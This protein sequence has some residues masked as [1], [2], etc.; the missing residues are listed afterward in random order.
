MNILVAIDSSAATHAALAATLARRWPEGTDFRV[1]TVIPGNLRDKFS[2]GRISPDIFRAHRLIDRATS[3]IEACNEDSI[4]TGEIDAGNPTQ[5]I[6]RGAD[7]WPADLVIVGSH[8]RGPLETLFM[9]S[10]SK[11]VMHKANCSVLVARNLVETPTGCSPMNRVMLAIDD[12]PYSKAAVDSVLRSMWPENTRFYI[13]SVSSPMY[14]G[15]AYEPS[16]MAVS[17]ALEY[18]EERHREVEEMVLGV[19]R[20]FEGTFGS[21]NVECG[22][23]EGHPEDVILKTARDWGAHLI[24]V[25]SHGRPDVAKRFLGSVSQT[26]AM[27]ADCSVQIVRS[28]VAQIKR[29]KDRSREVTKMPTASGF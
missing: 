23:I 12:S 6:T 10:V 13:L 11:S 8:E 9:G 2:G 17:W 20:Q 29:I 16:A 5:S 28:S 24:V 18:Q 7:V 22:V 4:V 21:G 19:S 15:F 1:L 25:G 14:S 3:E 26:V 27:K